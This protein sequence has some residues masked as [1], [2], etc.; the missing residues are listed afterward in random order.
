VAPETFILAVFSANH[1]R[2]C[3]ARITEAATYVY[4]GPRGISWA[5]P[6][7]ANCND[8]WSEVKPLFLFKAFKSDEGV[9][10]DL[11][12]AQ[13][14]N[15]PSEVANARRLVYGIVRVL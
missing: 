4:A 9:Q 12:D 15:A 7:E 11:R 6:S 5:L 13:R 8:W 1:Q 2:V 10:A 3:L 14:D